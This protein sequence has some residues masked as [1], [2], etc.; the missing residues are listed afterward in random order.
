MR[1]TVFTTLAVCLA[2]VGAARADDVT[3][4]LSDDL[5]QPASTV[6]S[7]VSDDLLQ[8]A[9]FGSDQKAD[10]KDSCDSCGGKGD[11]KGGKGGCSCYL[12]GPSEPF[13]FSSGDNCLG[14]K[15]GGWTQFGYH[16][17]ASY[18]DF[19]NQNP[20]QVHLHQQW[21]YAERVAD[22]SCGWDWG[23]RT[24]VL[25]GIDANNTQGFG[26]NPGVWDFQNG[27]D[28]G[29]YGF[30]LPQVYA[31]VA[32]G[33]LSVKVGHFYT[34][35]GYEVVAAPDNFF[36]SHAFTMNN[37]EPFT[38]TGA[39]G[40]YN[41]ND[42]VTAYGGWTAGWDTG[43]DQYGSGSSWLGGLSL[44]LTDNMTLTYM[45]T[46][47]DFG[48]LAPGEDD[49]YSHSI[50]LDVAVTDRLQYIF[51][52]DMLSAGN[53]N[54]VATGPTAIAETETIGINQYLIYTLNDCWAAGTRLEWWKHDGI[55]ANAATFG[56][57]YKPHAN[58]V[59]RPEV[60]HEWEP[61][62]NRDQ[63]IFG[64]DAILTY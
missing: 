48:F 6:S 18:H 43:F 12:F 35:I 49:S 62:M 50:V 11:G 9:S 38:H 40:T 17:K 54:T 60:K 52:S 14:I 31:E 47:G 36:Y 45:S 41:V 51:Q 33:D 13:E 23:F 22:G 44:S 63:T 46:Y 24:D 34:L 21:L 8:P 30:A 16:N 29:V 1:L 39:I 42:H 3:Y 26:N 37:S 4:N 64:M 2:L 20:N 5:V 7:D 55:S 28:H 27:F 58:L 19:F 15:F 59:F 32:K 10:Q 25:Y 53:S 57:N 56:V 61:G